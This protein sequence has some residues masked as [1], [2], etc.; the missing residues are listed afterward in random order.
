MKILPRIR[1]AHLPTP[2]EP[3]PRLS[4]FLEGP[5]ILIKRDDLTGL[6]MGGNKIRK[7]EFLF[8]EA[9][10]LGAKTL[11]T[12]GAIQ[13]N[14]CRQTA[15]VAARYGLECIIIL[16]SNE[17]EALNDSPEISGNLFLDH[18]FGA[19]IIFTTFT[20]RQNKLQEVFDRS[21]QS[22]RRPYLIPYGGS[23]PTGACGYVF[24]V[25]ELVKQEVQ[26]DWIVFASSSGG[27][28]AGLI[29]G[30]ELF[31][32][33]CKILGISVDLP[34]QKLKYNLCL[35][36]TQTAEL[37][38]ENI[39]FSPG[40]IGVNSDYLGMGYGK[41]GLKEKEAILLFSKYEG[42]VLDPVYTAKAAAGMI[43][44]VRKGFF[45]KGETILFL[46]TGGT[47]SLFTSEYTNKM[48]SKG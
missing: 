11:I 9:I 1:F 4:D 24:A 37:L 8:A 47:P 3:L 12:A 43:D 21:W 33:D 5:N 26:T 16:S 15:A 38:G 48:L 18:L 23:S 6:G 13:S 22:G 46:H 29:V 28:Q 25:E 20:E 32:P 44:L 41:L 2:V 36:A 27:T 34:S 42:I 39:S 19:E 30:K 35:L 14:H 17:N 31:L 40:E 45:K 7:L 10:A